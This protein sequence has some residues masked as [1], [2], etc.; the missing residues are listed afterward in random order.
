MPPLINPN[1]LDT[2]L[3]RHILREAVKKALLFVQAP[4]FQ[5][6]VLSPTFNATT[7]D[8]ID[9][10]IRQ[11]G[12]TIYHPVSTA[13]MSPFGADYGVVDPDLRVK[14]ASGLRIVDASIFPVSAHLRVG[15]LSER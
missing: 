2:D 3:D 12:R 6:Y 14:G 15:V 4:V 10:L 8:E 13:A 7:D 11:N 5:G 1:F 9:A